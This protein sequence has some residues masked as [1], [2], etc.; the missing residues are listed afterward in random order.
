MRAEGEERK[1]CKRPCS[2]GKAAVSTRC[3]HY[4]VNNDNALKIRK[5][6]ALWEDPPGNNKK[7]T[8]SLLKAKAGSWRACSAQMQLGRANA[9]PRGS[10]VYVPP[11]HPPRAQESLVKVCGVLAENS[12]LNAPRSVSHFP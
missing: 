11:D 2:A 8:F 12:T 10:P 4:L 7:L 1:H 6:R 3:R 5:A 9:S